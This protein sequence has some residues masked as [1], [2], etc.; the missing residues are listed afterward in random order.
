[1]AAL[2]KFRLG[3]EGYLLQERIVTH[4]KE[5]HN[6]L[7]VTWS[8]RREPGAMQK[9]AGLGAGGALPCPLISDVCDFGL[10]DAFQV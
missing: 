7:A 8:I 1:M 5:I 9:S 2:P 6:Q 4:L 3:W 10:E